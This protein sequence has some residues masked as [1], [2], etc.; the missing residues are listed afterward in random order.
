[1]ARHGLLHVPITCT[2][3]AVFYD[4]TNEIEFKYDDACTNSYDA[5]TVG[6]MDQTRT[7]GQT[8]R[9]RTSTQ[10]ITGTNPHPANYRISTTATGSSFESFDRG[11][12]GLVNA[13]ASDVMGSSSGTPSGYYCAS[14]YYWN[15]WANKCADNIPMP[16]GFNFTYFGTDYNYT[17]SNDRIN[18]GRHGNMHFLSS[19]STAL[20]RSMTTWY[21]N[22]PQLPYSSSSFARAGTIA[23]YW[24]YYGTYYC[25]QNSN[26][27]C[28]VYYR[29]MPFEGKGTD[30][31]SD[32]TQ[33]TTWDAT[34][35]PIRINPSGDYLTISADLTV[36]PGV[37]VQVAAGKGISFDGTCDQM[38]L[39]GNSTDH[40]LFEGADGAEWT[41]MAFTAACSSGTDDRH[42]FSYV[43]FA[44]TSDAAIS[45]GSRHGS[46]P[47]TNSNVGNFTMDH[48]TFT[49]VG[50]AFSHGSGQGTVVTMTDFSVDGA[51][52]A[53][54][55]FA[56]DTVATLTE[57]TMKDCNTDGN[58]AGGAIVNVAGIDWRCSL[59]R[60]HHSDQRIRQPH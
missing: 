53:C 4:V 33:D 37:T 15:T 20:V 48:V 43:D 11:L 56:E 44:N 23:P 1:M 52:S 9:H 49:D 5:A 34:D 51:D 35:S 7:M 60:E 54:F 46:S 13:D 8:I 38:T 40:I 55:D 19:G 32:I 29:T 47:S 31:S 22:M 30:V 14:S 57:G 36:Q 42:T 59:P 27:D 45:A 41:G 28:G 6:F 3:Q 21:G 12:S 18:L 39:N 2:Y 25:Y 16:D 50:S 17:D 26:Y 58:S 10:Y 24:S